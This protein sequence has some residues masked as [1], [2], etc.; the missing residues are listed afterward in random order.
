MSVRTS[1]STCA[2]GFGWVTGLHNGSLAMNRYQFD[3]AMPADDAQLRR[4]LAETPME[5]HISLSFCREPS[6]F[7]AAAVDGRFRQTVA[8][9]DSQV[10]QAVGFGS[11]SVSNRFVNGQVRP[12]G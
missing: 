1:I 12:V 2:R 4:I 6:Y 8:A 5:G 10:G 7:E 3:L 11:R 9:R